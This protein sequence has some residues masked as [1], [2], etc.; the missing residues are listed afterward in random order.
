[1]LGSDTILH[2]PVEGVGMIK[3]RVQGE[4]A[5]RH[6]Q[7]AYLTPDPTKIQL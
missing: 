4:F 6:G 5:L 3:A 2:V 1:M 7:K